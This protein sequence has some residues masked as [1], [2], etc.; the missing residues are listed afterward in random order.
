[1]SMRTGLVQ[2]F[3]AFHPIA[4]YPGVCDGDLT[5][6]IYRRPCGAP[7][8][9]TGLCSWG[10]FPRHPKEERQIRGLVRLFFPETGRKTI[11]RGK[12]RGRSDLERAGQLL[13]ERGLL[14]PPRIRDNIA[15]PPRQTVRRL[16]NPPPPRE[17]GQSPTIKFARRPSPWRT[18]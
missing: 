7:P 18:D 9:W 8:P 12:P 4:A 6:R 1:M 17:E 10:G 11:A 14:L 16:A 13:L 15:A 2:S 5:E 3:S